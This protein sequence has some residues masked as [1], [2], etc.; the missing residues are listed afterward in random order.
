M[1]LLETWCHMIPGSQAEHYACSGVLDTLELSYQVVRQASQNRVTV[2]ESTDDKAVNELFK[3][4][5]AD[6]IAF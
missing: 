4:C 3:D 6:T 2:V 1:E 5:L